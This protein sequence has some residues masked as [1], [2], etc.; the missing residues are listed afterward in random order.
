MILTGI[1]RCYT[2]YYL[3]SRLGMLLPEKYE[4]IF[5][6]SSK[7]P[8]LGSL[9]KGSLLKF[10]K[11]TKLGKFTKLPD[12][13]PLLETWKILSYF[14]GRSI[15]NLLRRYLKSL[16]LHWQ[17]LFIIHFINMSISQNSFTSKSANG[18]M[19]SCDLIDF[20]NIG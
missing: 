3:R 11:F 8:S 16:Y 15:P 5:N 1:C 19:N 4:S 18:M 6:V 20:V 7:G 2:F 9:V 14:S 12:E 17:L 10:T 13:G